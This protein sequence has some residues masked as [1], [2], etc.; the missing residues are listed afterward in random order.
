[1]DALADIDPSRFP[2]PVRWLGLAAL[3]SLLTLLFALWI[4]P[5]PR[6]AGALSDRS[7]A[8]VGIPLHFNDLGPTLG[9]GGLGIEATQVRATLPRG[10]TLVIPRVALRPAFSFGW[11]TGNPSI[12]VDLEGG[13]LGNIEGSIALGAGGGFDGSLERIALALL[14]LE[15]VLPNLQMEGHVSG[16]VDVA[17]DAAGHP[18][19]RLDFEA[20]EGS[21]NAPGMPIGIPFKTFTGKIDLGGEDY[22]VIEVLELTGPMLYA[23]AVGTV[24]RSEP[25]GNEPLDMELEIKPIGRALAPALRE[26]GIDAQPGKPTT[27]QITGTLTRPTFR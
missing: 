22:A 5:Y 2:R 26:L 25:A 4:F 27:L 19:G 13:G 15:Q 20:V 21:I 7:E 10:E 17:I 11:L 1:M 23:K 6:L 14:P 8:L 9:L 3:G 16:Q 18:E 12:F 24:A